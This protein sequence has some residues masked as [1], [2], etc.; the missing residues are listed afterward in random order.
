[1]SI[2]DEL[3]KLQDLHRTG[4]L[5]DEEFAAAKAAVLAGGRPGSAPG[6]ALQGH[7]ELIERQNEV[8]RL[9]REWQS[10][11]ERYM[12]AGRYGY[13]YIPTRGMSVLG[14][15]A[16]TAFGILWTVMA[17]S[18]V[19]LAGGVF[20]LFPLFG[21][22]FTLM[23]IGVSVYSYTKAGQYE[24]AERAYRQRRARLMGEKTEPP[25]AQ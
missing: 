10:E 12:V 18:M 11:R 7:I 21:V 1:M 3:R 15:V 20:A 22:L 2:A 17:A 6:E 16:I 19:G 9:D 5:T 23:G 24:A 25:G 14:G 13:R 8:A 4:A